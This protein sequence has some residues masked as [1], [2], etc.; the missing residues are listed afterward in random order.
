MIIFLSAPKDI[1]PSSP[2]FIHFFWWEVNYHSCHCS[3][4]GMSLRLF[5]LCLGFSSVTMVCLCMTYLVLILLCVHR[6]SCICKFMSH[7]KYLQRYWKILPIISTQTTGHLWGLFLFNRRNARSTSKEE[8]R[9]IKTV[10]TITFPS[11]HAKF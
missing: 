1:I 6:A 11:I 8:K 5:F 3:L 2:V 7:T 9:N 4:H 10:T